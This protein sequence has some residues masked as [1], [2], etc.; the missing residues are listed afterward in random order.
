MQP[1]ILAVYMIVPSYCDLPEVLSNQ[2]WNNFGCRSTKKSAIEKCK[3]LMKLHKIGFLPK[4]R[5][6]KDCT[7]VGAELLILG[8]HELSEFYLRN[9]YQ[10]L[11]S[12]KTPDKESLLIVSWNLVEALRLT[13]KYKE[14]ERYL[15]IYGNLYLDRNSEDA[16]KEYY[17]RNGQLAI[18]QGK[19]ESAA[20]YLEMAVDKAKIAGSDTDGFFYPWILSE[21]IYTYCELG[22]Y[23]GAKWM[24]DY[25]VKHKE[26]L[27]LESTMI[28]LHLAKYY[29][30]MKKY[31]KA[32]HHIMNI[33]NTRKLHKKIGYN[34]C[35]I[36]GDLYIRKREFTLAHS[37]YKQSY[38]IL[39][40]YYSNNHSS[41]RKMRAKLANTYQ[42]DQ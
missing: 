9:A 2:I 23:D 1:V 18:A 36:L 27:S 25:C 22:K 24:L 21:L 29:K 13:G 16:L 39:R 35:E 17:H 34:T 30:H 12:Q 40:K 32:E 20:L 28:D 33:L 14:A 5:F 37:C 11:K 31:H 6:V 3:R 7:K 42:H 15:A 26:K 8:E 10:E 41:V 19:F 38:T 4:D